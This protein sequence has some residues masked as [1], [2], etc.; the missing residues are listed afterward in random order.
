MNV[1][2]WESS[3][4][5]EMVHRP[6]QALKKSLLTAPVVSRVNS[7]GL[8]LAVRKVYVCRDVQIWRVITAA[9][10][11]FLGV[12]LASFHQRGPSSYVG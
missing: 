6:R 2:I 10:T 4:C 3:L 11:G 7:V 8:R 1:G 12:L 5:V 9:L